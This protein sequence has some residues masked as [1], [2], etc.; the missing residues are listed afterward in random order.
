M[1]TLHS[2]KWIF[3]D[4][5]VFINSKLKL[6]EATVTPIACFAAGLGV[7]DSMTFSFSML[8]LKTGA[9]SS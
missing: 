6:F 9:V 5:N 1:R 4:K 2:H 7:S 3:L 8:N